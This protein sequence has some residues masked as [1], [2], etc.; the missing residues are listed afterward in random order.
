MG[1]HA[2][3]DLTRCTRLAAEKL[4]PPTQKSTVT[5]VDVACSPTKIL[6]NQTSTCTATVEG[7]N[8]P[9]QAVGWT[10]SGTGASMSAIGAFA[11]PSSVSTETSFVVTATST[12]DPTKSGTA[13]V[14]VDP[15]PP[16]VTKVD[17]ACSPAKIIANQKS[18]CAATVEGTNNP[19]QEVVWKVDAPL[20]YVSTN[21][22][23]SAP[24]V[25]VTTT[26]TIVA[27]SDLD[28]TKTG[29]ATVTVDPVPP[30]V[31][32]VIAACTPAKILANQTSSCTA[33]V[34]GTNNPSQEVTWSESGSGA[35]ITQVGRFTPPTSLSAET[36][37]T[38][39]ATSKQDPDEKRYDYH[40]R[41]SRTA[42]RDQGGRYLR[43]GE[44][45]R[46]SE[47]HL[48]GD[49]G[50]DKQ[51]QPGRELVLQQR[52][53]HARRGLHGHK[54]DNCRSH[55]HH[56]RDVRRRPVKERHNYDHY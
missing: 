51:S 10:V 46:R 39:T 54:R 4:P 50:R 28:K 13:T 5:K 18:T 53:D 38:I 19:S 16:T 49:G 12:Q 41:G 45:P 35:N 25:T 43:T 24:A 34:Q 44:N 30:E 52:L 42:D 22:V 15:V 40:H 21:G 23:F 31:T 37:Y 33:T 47:K 20:G 6:A 29:S 36:T 8:N 26:F 48:H 17:V 1:A 3:R 7:T 56:H 2:H 14:T 55:G 32:G 27:T 9:S 11:P